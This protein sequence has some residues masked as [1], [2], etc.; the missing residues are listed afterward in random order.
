MWANVSKKSH[1]LSFLRYSD[2]TLETSENRIVKP[3][4]YYGSEEIYHFTTNLPPMM[5]DFVQPT[6]QDR[7]FT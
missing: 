3:F 1:L 4:V 7:P 2:M 6:T 5:H